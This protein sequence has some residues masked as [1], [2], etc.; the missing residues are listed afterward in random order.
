[1]VDLLAD[2]IKKGKVILDITQCMAGSVELGRYETSRHLRDI[3]VISGFD[4]TFEAAIT[5]L[6][7]V[8]GLELS[9]ADTCQL[10]SENLRGELTYLNE[11]T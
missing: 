2:A 9:Y 7:F 6:M 4:M 3:G 11:L 5:K 8:L 1:L 10:L